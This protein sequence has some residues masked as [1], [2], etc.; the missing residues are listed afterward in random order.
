[1]LNSATAETLPT[2]S[3]VPPMITISW[4]RWRQ[5]RLARE[6]LR[7]VRERT[8]RDQRQ[9]IRFVRQ[10]QVHE[11]VDRVARRRQA[12]GQRQADVAHAVLAVDELGRPEGPGERLGRVRRG[13]ARSTRRAPACTGRSG[14][15][16]PAGRCRRPRSRPGPR[17]PGARAPSG[18]RR[19]H[20]SRVGVDD[21]AERS[22]VH[23]RNL[24]ASAGLATA[25]R[26]RSGSDPASPAGEAE[27]GAGQEGHRRAG[28]A[29]SCRARRTSAAGSSSP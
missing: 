16:D 3:D 19:R 21:Q 8:E 13:P 26:R 12:T 27:D 15:Q 4:R 22:V 18:G 29:R 10:D 20:R 6:R 24:P 1:M 7:H 14:R 2:A 9:R 25:R 5:R 28:R 11:H 23:R 17:R